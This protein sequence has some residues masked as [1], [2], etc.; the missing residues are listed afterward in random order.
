VRDGTTI[1]FSAATWTEN[2]RRAIPL[3]LVAIRALQQHRKR[4]ES[5]REIAVMANLR[6]ETGLVFTNYSGGPLD[7][8]GASKSFQ[9]VLKRE[10]LPHQRFHDLHHACASMLL[11]QG[12]ELKV[13]QEI[14]GHSTITITADLFAQRQ[15][16]AQMDAM[17]GGDVKDEDVTNVRLVEVGR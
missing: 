17:L 10:G 8:E 2:S 4:Q 11:A 12:L 15:A 5:E 14:L 16:A 6:R 7:P 1:S 13:I 3:P 9:R